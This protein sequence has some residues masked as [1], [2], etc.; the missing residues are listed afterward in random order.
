MQYLHK[1][2]CPSI[3]SATSSPLSNGLID[4]ETTP[5]LSNSMSSCHEIARQEE[6]ER[7]LVTFFRS[8]LNQIG[9]ISKWCWKHNLCI[10]LQSECESLKTKIA[11]LEERHNNLAIKYIQMKAKRKFQTEELGCHCCFTQSFIV[12][13]RVI[14]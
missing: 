4:Y 8:I 6:N 12:S 14:L 10:R 9:R 11:T 2:L 1:L 5:K 13:I 3:E 7:L